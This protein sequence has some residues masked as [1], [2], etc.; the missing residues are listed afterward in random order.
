MTDTSPLT[1]GR[2]Y[3]LVTCA[4]LAWLCAGILMAVPPLA[5]RSAAAS[6][7]VTAEALRGRWFSWYVCAFLLGAASGGFIFGW[8]G[9]HIGRAKA[10]GLSVLTYSLIAGSCYFVTTPEQ[11]LVLWYLACTGVGGVW[12]NGVSLAA[13]ALPGMS[14]P[15]IS[16]LFGC[17]ANLGLMLLLMLAW[18]HT[19][20][21][22]HWRWVMLVAAS[23]AV[24]GVI[25]LLFVPESPAWL[26]SRQLVDRSQKRSLVREVFR[27]P[28]LRLTIIGILLGAVPLMGNWGATNW[29]VPWADQV[30]E[31]SGTAGLKAWT[32]W[33][34]SAG[35][36]IGSLLGGCVAS[37]CGRR[38]AYFAM[39]LAALVSSSYIFRFLSPLDDT[40]LTWVLI[41]GFFGTIY[42]GWLPLYLPELFPTR[43]RATGTGVTFNWGRILTA[44]GVLLGGQLMAAY[45][46][47]YPLVGQWTCLVYAVGLVVICFAPDTSRARLEE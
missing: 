46:M 8:I 42:F 32:Q 40:F 20:T 33:M 35:G 10:L 4:L 22:D 24:L 14:R 41:Q 15:W 23:P 5:A 11:M 44:F 30:Q 6:M 47:N 26:A 7:G 16:G 17:T 13:E 3:T 28:L 12:P 39:S 27:P 45:N 37:L 2:R 19:I 25:I 38:T 21:P 34:K 29:L 18:R 9:D 31:Q 43:V 36:A 1:T